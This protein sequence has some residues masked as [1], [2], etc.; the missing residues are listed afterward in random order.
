MLNPKKI[1][2]SISLLLFFAFCMSA[3]A[4]VKISNLDDFNFGRYS[5][6]GNLRNDDNIC[7]NTIPNANYRITFWGSGAGGSF[8][9]TNG[10]NALGYRVRFNDRARRNGGRTM[11]PGVPLTNRRRATTDIDCPSGLNANID[12]R[13]RRQDLQAAAPGRY[14]GTLTVTVAP[15]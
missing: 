10:V 3:S 5:G 14:I 12:I 9:I 11:T 8:E 13:F 2:K 6:N 4:D 15:E 7:I 1:Q